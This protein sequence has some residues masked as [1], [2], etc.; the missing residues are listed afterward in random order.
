[1]MRV[2]SRGAN[3]RVFGAPSLLVLLSVFFTGC[4]NSCFLAFSNP[5]N[6]V[7]GVVI[8][9]PPA[10]CKLTTPKGAVFIVMQVSRSCEPCSG[11]N[12]VRTVVLSLS[13]IDLHSSA[14]AADESSSWQALLPELGSQPRRVELLSGELTALSF[15]S[16]EELPIPAGSY[17]LVRLSLARDQVLA[18]DKLFPG[19]PCGK[20]E[21]NCVIMMDGQIAPLVF[22]EDTLEFRLTSEATVGGL[23]LVMPDSN[24][25]LLI[26]LTP[27]LSM[28]RPFGE[29]TR[30]FSIFPG[31]AHM[32]SRPR[33]KAPTMPEAV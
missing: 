11:S 29:A 15:E 26:E 23:S 24:N 10:A 27:V 6:G 13:G 21:P 12:R 9:S 14:Y 19:N 4:A 32:E 17:D 20:A 31:T 18:E 5:P 25:Q 3:K 1:M 28:A 8:S 30:S 7:I 22:E 33:G 2:A 16:S